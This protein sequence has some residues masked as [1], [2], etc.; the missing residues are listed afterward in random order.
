[1]ATWG[2]LDVAAWEDGATC[3]DGAP[4]VSPVASVYVRWAKP[5]FDVVAAT[6]LVI[7]LL[8]VLV[9]VAVAV[10]LTLG[11]GVLYRQERVGRDGRV[12]PVFKFRTM[13][14]DRRSRRE[15][16]DGPDRRV[17]HKRDDDPRHTRLGRFLRRT[18]LDELPQLLNVLR[19]EMSLVGP[20]PELTSVVEA[21][22]LWDHPR[23][24][25][26][27]GITGVWQISPARTRLLHEGVHLDLQYL[28]RITLRR[29]LGILVGTALTIARRTGS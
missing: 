9:A 6:V 3:D 4:W 12:F 11:P 26:K 20:R 13:R 28:E 23:H 25:V 29:D 7:L 1:M 22:G 5:V 8:P 14:P 17:C 18:S 24:S 19:G 27:P 2:Q 10:R 16:F 21:V 15:P